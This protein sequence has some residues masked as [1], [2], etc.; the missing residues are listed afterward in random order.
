MSRSNLNA[1]VKS[2]S[3]ERQIERFIRD[4]LKI[5]WLNITNAGL[6]K[7]SKI[8][9]KTRAMGGYGKL[10]KIKYIALISE[11]KVVLLEVI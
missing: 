9:V 1:A 6:K 4:N 8:L 11:F 3:R 2:Y 7:F 5:T 10:S